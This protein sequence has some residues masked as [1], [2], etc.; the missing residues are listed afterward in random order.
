MAVWL[1][2]WTVRQEEIGKGKVVNLKKEKVDRE[3]RER[4]R[5]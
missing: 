5:A 3:S 1:Q 4:S 2:K